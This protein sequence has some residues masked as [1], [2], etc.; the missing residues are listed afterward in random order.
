MVNLPK[1]NEIVIA[2]A[3]RVLEHGAYFSL[4]EY[5]NIEAYMPIGEVSSTRIIDIKDAIKEGKKYV[6][7]VIRVDPSRNYIDI[8]LKRVTEQERKRK[9]IEWKRN[10]KA[11]KLLDLVAAKLKINKQSLMIKLSPYIGSDFEDWLALFEKP[12]KEGIEI[13]DKLNLDDDL[14][15]AILEVA[16]EHIKVPIPEI[17][18][19]ITLTTLAKDGVKKIKEILSETHQ[20]L[21]KIKGIR[22]LDISYL[23][24]SRFL[25]KIQAANFKIAENAMEKLNEFLSQRSPQLEI[26][27]SFKRV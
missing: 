10:Q 7:K 25:V 11:E 24:S 6:C 17:K 13:L 9:L 2:T 1:P 27:Y 26:T 21:L 14:K 8:S 18:A 15:K 19:E 16:N 4:D 3:R 20:E 22:D 12:L 23:G 5:N